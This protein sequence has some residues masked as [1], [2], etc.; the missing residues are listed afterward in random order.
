MKRHLHRHS[1]FYIQQAKPINVIQV[2]RVMTG[3]RG[4]IDWE[5]AWGSLQGSWKYSIYLKL[6]SGYKPCAYIKIHEL[7]YLWWVYFTICMLYLNKKNPE[8]PIFKLYQS[9]KEP[10]FLIQQL[11]DDLFKSS[12]VEKQFIALNKEWKWNIISINFLALCY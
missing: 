1:L 11:T 8:D 9:H 7:H 12:F 6:G 2:R 4:A 5:G 3:W 10:S